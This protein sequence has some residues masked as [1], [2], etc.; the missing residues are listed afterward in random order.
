MPQNKLINLKKEKKFLGASWFSQTLYKWDSW[1][2]RRKW[3]K[4]FLGI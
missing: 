3:Y 2:F 1:N 4:N